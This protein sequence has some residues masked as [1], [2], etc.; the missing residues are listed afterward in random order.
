MSDIL[1]RWQATHELTVT[2][3]GSRMY[4]GDDGE[5]DYINIDN[6]NNTSNNKVHNIKLTVDNYS[7]G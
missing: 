5:N 1:Q 7:D 6:N 3:L 4:T 2:Y